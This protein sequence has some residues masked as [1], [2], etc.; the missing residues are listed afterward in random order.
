MLALVGLLW[1][2]EI[3]TPLTLDQQLNNLSIPLIALKYPCILNA[4]ELRKS[5]QFGRWLNFPLINLYN[6][7]LMSDNEIDKLIQANI[8][9]TSAIRQAGCKKLENVCLFS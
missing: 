2:H 3:P 6:S 7:S 1:L 8:L 9:T 4:L 5:I